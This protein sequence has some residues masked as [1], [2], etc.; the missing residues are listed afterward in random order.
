MKRKNDL[1][2]KIYHSIGNVALCEHEERG[3]A[4][5]WRMIEQKAEKNL[6]SS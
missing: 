2:I 3:I 5:R 6:D 1:R 4:D